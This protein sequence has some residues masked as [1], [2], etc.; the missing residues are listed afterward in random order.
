M[1]GEKA[2]D[3]VKGIVRARSPGTH[4]PVPIEHTAGRAAMRPV[5]SEG[6]P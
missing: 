2:A 1:I 3:L 4:M 6:N 5:A